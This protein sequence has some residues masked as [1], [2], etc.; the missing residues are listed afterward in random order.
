MDG[1]NHKTTKTERPSYKT[2]QI[3]NAKKQNVPKYKHLSYNTS[4][5]PQNIQSYYV[6]TM[7]NLK[8]RTY[9][10]CVRNLFKIEYTPQGLQ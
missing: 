4:P 10:M 9:S 1:Y 8:I 5:K 6:K 2:S 7:C 3:Q